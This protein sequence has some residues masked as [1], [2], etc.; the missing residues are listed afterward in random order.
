MRR[1][2][3]FRL[4]TTLSAASPAERTEL[5]LSRYPN[6]FDPGGRA[7]DQDADAPAR[8]AMCSQESM[9]RLNALPASR[10]A[11]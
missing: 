11:R 4:T 1:C 6:D 7:A 8:A 5:K 2:T 9:H 3:A 10:L